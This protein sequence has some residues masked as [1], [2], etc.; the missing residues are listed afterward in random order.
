MAFSYQPETG[1]LSGVSFESQTEAFLQRASVG[2]L[3]S[4]GGQGLSASGAGQETISLDGVPFTV[5]SKTFTAPS[6]G[7]YH[8]CCERFVQI[9]NNSNGMVDIGYNSGTATAMMPVSAGQTVK[10]LWRNERAH[11]IFVKALEA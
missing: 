1:V 9:D 5:N 4:S 6:G 8:A 2:G 7:Y 3:P 10:I 11:L